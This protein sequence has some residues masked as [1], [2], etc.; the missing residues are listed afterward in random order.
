MP[1]AAAPQPENETTFRNI[2]RRLASL[3]HP[4]RC[5]L[6][7]AHIEHYHGTEAAAEAGDEPAYSSH[8][9]VEITD[10]TVPGALSGTD[11]SPIRIDIIRKYART[12]EAAVG[13]FDLAPASIAVRRT[14]AGLQD[15]YVS[16]DAIIGMAIGEVVLRHSWVLRQPSS[17]DVS[18]TEARI[19]KYAAALGLD[20]SRVLGELRAL[21]RLALLRESSGI[22]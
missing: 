16:P 1:P 9:K 3:P 17:D 19:Q 2:I 15:V 4:A 21:S 20:S 11:L 7:D 6:V 12:G 13:W 8:V 22:R 10:L 14:V 5:R 18:R